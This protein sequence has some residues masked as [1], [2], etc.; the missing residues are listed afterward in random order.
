MKS[1]RNSINHIINYNYLKPRER[2]IRTRTIWVVL[3]HPHQWRTTEVSPGTQGQMEKGGPGTA[4]LL[5]RE[6]SCQK[7]DS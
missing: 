3:S 6:D 5:S 2:E 7:T 4:G 1:A